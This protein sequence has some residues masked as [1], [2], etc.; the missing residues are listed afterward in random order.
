MLATTYRPDPNYPQ[1][2]AYL[3]WFD[4][5]RTELGYY[6]GRYEPPTGPYADPRW[7][8]TANALVCSR[9]SMAGSPTSMVT[10]GLRTT[11]KRTSP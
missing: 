10:T 9:P 4:H 3:A 6:P 8:P 2:V 1:I 7:S 5:S 11:A